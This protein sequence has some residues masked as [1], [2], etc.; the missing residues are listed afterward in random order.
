LSE[1]QPQGPPRINIRVSLWELSSKQR[2][3]VTGL[4][5]DMGFTRDEVAEVTVL[6][7]LED[8]PAGEGRRR[9]RK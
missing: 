9:K 1:D 8:E 4:L 3:A 6:I 5:K 7:P 2:G